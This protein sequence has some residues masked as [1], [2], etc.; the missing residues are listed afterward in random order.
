MKGWVVVLVGNRSRQVIAVCNSEEE[1]N[2]KS[3]NFKK[4]GIETEV[5]FL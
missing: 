2:R 1:A 4:M 3:K 5:V